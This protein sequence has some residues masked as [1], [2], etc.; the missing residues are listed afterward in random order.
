MSGHNAAW[1]AFGRWVRFTGYA[2]IAVSGIILA[3]ELPLGTAG[4]LYVLLSGWMG[5][6]GLLCAAG[7]LLDRW[8]GEFIGLPL[9]STAMAAFGGVT[10]QAT[11]WNGYGIANFCLLV[12]LGLLFGGR[13]LDHSLPIYRSAARSAHEESQ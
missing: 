13:W 10:V 9:L 11:H 2:G 3:V 6:G 1:R 8:S 12:G 4:G 7:M 5:L